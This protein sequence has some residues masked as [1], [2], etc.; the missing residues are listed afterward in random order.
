M[1]PRTIDVSEIVETGCFLIKRSNVSAYMY[2][3]GKRV[4]SNNDLY[5]G[6]DDSLKE[7]LNSKTILHYKRGDITIS[8]NEFNSKPQ[9]RYDDDSDEE[10][11]RKMANKKELEGFEP[12]YDE[13]EFEDVLFN[14]TKYVIDT[15]SK[16]ISCTP[17]D[18][19]QKESFVYTVHVRKAAMDEYL[20]LAEKYATI[21]SFEKPDREYLRF[22][23]I[24][25]GFA[26]YEGK[27]FS[28]YGYDCC[29][30]SLDGAKAEEEAAR[31]AVRRVVKRC[32]FKK[33]GTQF[34]LNSIVSKIKVAKSVAT[35]KC[36]N[37]ILSDII[38]DIKDYCN[39]C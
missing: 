27:P 36:C 35:K 38:K 23:K 34:Y 14:I 33:E 28:D 9:R 17:R 15:G 26:F 39:N 18:T 5:I 16:F 32:V 2:L 25:N 24:N 4:D 11:L 7:K 22:T 12:V 3:N 20:I 10:V 30:V 1:A 29:F 19:Y 21:A 8:V 13:K 31:E 37:E 6:P